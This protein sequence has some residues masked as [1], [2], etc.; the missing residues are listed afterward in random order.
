MIREE[1]IVGMVLLRK[2]S[3]YAYVIVEKDSENI[4]YTIKDPYKKVED[5]E[6][7]PITRNTLTH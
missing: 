7:W 1:I 3:D 6:E 5:D 4:S 2:M